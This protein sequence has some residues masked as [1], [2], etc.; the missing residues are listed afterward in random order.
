[1]YIRNTRA[2]IA[3]VNLKRAARAGVLAAALALNGVP[4]WPQ[5]AAPDL[6]Q[7]SLKDLMNIEVTSV[8]QKA[9]K[10]SRTA[11]AVFV[12]TPEDIRRSG[13][14]NLPDLLRMVPGVDVA[15]IDSNTWAISV[16]GL[17]QRFS[18]ELL[19]LVDGRSVYTTEFG[20]VYWDTLDLPLEDIERI[21][22]I[23]GPGGSAW[24]ANAVNGVINI[25]TRKT[26]D[27]LGA[28]VV[29]GGGNVQEGFGTLQ[30]GG[31]AGSSITYR[32]YAKY[33]NDD[34][35]PDPMNQDGA[36]G[37]RSLRGGF[38][39]DA[40]PTAKDSL[41]FQGDIYTDRE[42]TPAFDFPSI[43][44]PGLMPVNVTANLSGGFLEG[45][46]NHTF[47]AQS[48]TTLQVSYDRSE[49]GGLLSDDRGTL[50]LNF[51]HQYR[52]WSR[53]NLVWGLGYN[54][55]ASSSHGDFFVSFIPADLTT[56]LFSAFVQ[57][58][59]TLAPDRLF[60]TAG[61]RLE[62]NYYT[63]V[64]AMPSARLAWTPDDHQTVWAAV[65][66]A[67]RSPAQIDA[68]FRANLAT[69]TEPDGTL[70]L[71]ALFGNPHV[72]DESLIAYEF[73]YRAS[74][75]D[76]LSV[77][78]AAYYNDYNHQETDEPETPF[79]E[80]TPAPP[81]L[82][83]PSTFENLMHGEASGFEISAN[84]KPLNRWTLSPGYA[85]EGIHMHTDPTSKDTTSAALAEGSSPVHSAQLRSHVTLWRSLTW[86]ASTYF[87][88]RLRDPVI[89]SYTR[90]DTQ[91]SWKFGE[92]GTFSLVGQ[93]L[94]KDHHEEFFDATSSTRT[95]E[96]KRSAFAKFTW[97]F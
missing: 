26:S 89:P 13:S 92:R 40:A 35:Y 30:Y 4:A 37:W 72:D 15:Q 78:F 65:S 88:D 34:H 45:A 94:L 79:F 87:V 58:E 70:A 23:R 43:T 57:D 95:T 61:I 24:G 47:S 18:N 91:L 84:W 42:G 86:D 10:L 83:I 9:E 20:G 7:E 36:D 69:F 80:N 27:T 39:I 21:E 33:F 90:F 71:V 82:V 93:N 67:V 22:V 74:I 48:I 85:F 68:G 77:D 17:N 52:G 73:G 49:R 29:S 75:R 97:K 19:V 51:Q 64:N 60:L 25:I 81:H 1:M 14:T 62:H 46:W 28:L 32:A 16:R 96:M 56:H 66:D 8:S 6:T 59:I 54:H 38:R 2:V 44:S 41:T 55:V 31:N 76:R 3:R 11:S 53:Q 63:G 12:I 5:Q 50:N